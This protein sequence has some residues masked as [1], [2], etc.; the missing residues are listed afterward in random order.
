MPKINYYSKRYYDVKNISMQTQD[1]FFKENVTFT[2]KNTKSFVSKSTRFS[3]NLLG[4][5]LLFFVSSKKKLNEPNNT[6]SQH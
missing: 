3:N 1:L 2:L 4:K 5:D 6:P